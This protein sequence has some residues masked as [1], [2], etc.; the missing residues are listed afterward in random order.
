MDSFPEVISPQGRCP[1]ERGMVSELHELVSEFSEEDEQ[2]AVGIEVDRGLLVGAL[3]GA[4]YEVYAINPMAASRYRDR[5]GVSGA[6]SDAGY[7]KVLA[8]LV[9]TDRHNHRVAGSDSELVDAIRVLARSH[10]SAIW[11][12]QRQVNSLRSALREFCPG[13]LEAF[14]TGLA[15]GDAVGVLAV[16]PLPSSGAPCLV[17]RS[18]RPYVEVGGAEGSRRS[19]TRSSVSCVPSTSRPVR[20][21]PGP[22]GSS[23][24]RASR[25]SRP[26]TGRS[27]SS[28]R[29]WPNILRHTRPPR[30]S[31]PCQDSG[32]R[33]AAGCSASS[34][35]T[36]TAMPA[37][38]LARTTP[39]RRPSPRPR[40]RA[41]SSCSFRPQPSPGRCL[42]PV[43]F[44]FAH[45][46]IRRPGV[47]RRPPRQGQDPPPGSTPAGQPL[48]GDP[49]RLPGDGRTL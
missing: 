14:G 23:P 2:V 29:L 28:K 13:A 24:A 15:S 8:D 10:Q 6:K 18:R 43:G 48:G 42:G 22:M 36:R 38:S 37:P 32:R 27:N 3:V 34:G 11:S 26:S 25:S 47:L 7:A 44:L 1:S 4:G 46:I 35:T 12:R 45:Q 41:D 33:S 5:H 49:P 17:R 20:S 30:S 19:P 21:F 39:A 31:A 16:A 9:R 40:A